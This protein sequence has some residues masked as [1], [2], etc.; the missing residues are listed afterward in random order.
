MSAPLPA[1]EP[2]RLTALRALDVLDTP[3]EQ[4]YDDLSALAAYVCQTPVALISLV[5]ENRQ[6]FKSR[7]GWTTSESPREVAFCAHTILQSDLLVVP[8]ARADER[9][10]N[11][12]LVTSPPSIRFY[13]G[14]PLVTDEGYVLGTL[15][16][17]DHQ[18]RELTTEQGR[19]LRIVSHQVMAQLQLGKQLE[20]RTRSNAQLAELNQ[21]LRCEVGQRVQVEKELRKSRERFELAVRG[22]QNGLWDW[23]LETNEVYYSPRWKSILGY[24]D[25]E[26][27]NRLEEWS[28]RLHPEERET[29][30]AANYAHIA[31]STPH[32][33]YE[34][35]LRH[36]DGSYRW[37]LSRGVAKRD[38]QG[39]AFRMAGSHTDLTDR[40]YIE[41]ALHQAN[42]R[43]ALAIRGSNIGIWE[44][45]LAGGNYSS[46]R[47][48]CIN[49]MEPL[50]Y[51]A[52]ESDVE[53]V[54]LAAQVH[55][56]DRPRVEQA[57]NVYLAGESPEYSVEFRAQ[58]RD[59]SYVWVLSRGVLVRDAAGRPVRF[60]GTRIDITERKR[61]EDALR[62]SVERFRGTFENAG[63]GIAHADFEGRWLRV[64]EKL[65]AI[66]GY[67]RDELL[68]KTF[69]DITHL[70]D[71]PISL[72]QF[73]RLLRR[74]ISGYTLEKRYVRKN[75]ST[76][77]VDLAVSLQRD[78]ADKPVY[79]I[80]V[81]QDISERKRLETEL[82]QAKEAAE[83]A[84]RAKSD[85]LA[86]VSHEVRTPLNAIM[87]MN[88]LALDTP[89]TEQQRKYL[90]V[91][92]SASEDLLEMIN[93][94]LDFSK[95]EAGKLD[96]DRSPFSLR[97]V[98]NDTMRSVALRAHR[99]GL[100]LA[101]H[102]RPQVADFFIGD[103]GRLRQV[104]TNLVANAVKF[105]DQ[106][107]VVIE[108]E[109]LEEESR[110]NPG[111]HDCLDAVPCTLLFS[112]RDTGIGIPRDKQQ[113]IFEAFE[114]VDKSTT[115]RYGGTGLG[116]SI[117]S[118]LVGLMG[119]RIT[120][121]SE[122]GR[123]STFYFTVRLN[124]PRLQ[125]HRATE[126]APNELQALRV[127]VVD[128]S[129]A[130]RSILEEW[131]RAW[132]VEATVVSDGTAALAALRQAAA[133]DR[134]YA[135]VVLDSRLGGSDALAVAEQIRQTPDLA[136]TGILLLTV[137]D[138]ATETRKWHEL[139][140]QACLMKPVA[141]EELLDTICRMRS[142]PG[143]AV[144]AAAPASRC[145]YPSAL[146]TSGALQSE[147]RL[148]ILVA[149]DN[150][151]NQA[152][153]QELLP[154]RGHTL[155]VVLDGRA[156]L[157][158][159][160]E[161]CFNVMLLDIHMPELDGFQVVAAQRQRENGTKHRL[162]IIALTA[163]STEGERE[164]CLQ[165]GMDDYLAKPVRAAQ[166]FAALDRVV[167]GAT[168]DGEKMRDGDESI[169]TSTFL[170]RPSSF[171][172]SPS[173][174]DAETLLA[175]CDGDDALLRKMCKHFQIF[176]P[177]RLAE[178]SEALLDQNGPMVQEAAHKL[179]GMVSSFSAVAAQAAA[180]L[181]HLGKERKFEE[182]MRAYPR[183]TELVGEV[184]SEIDILSIDQLQRLA[185]SFIPPH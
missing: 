103:S 108:A 56:D 178:L 110:P 176:V 119:G 181:G 139:G 149:E 9:F 53:Y 37:I 71:L 152:V 135:L 15:C 137:E 77:W 177:G 120:V 11:N 76:I 83:A 105:T 41:A 115:R 106:G 145:E 172:A 59:G 82:R 167:R 25:H 39:K 95:I 112:V 94:L 104:L 70:D 13:A 134:P 160:E 93:D 28:D 114:Q 92:Q 22:S 65:C 63:V 124:R 62:E 20:E 98:L 61:A 141:E 54:Q 2:D 31:G 173:K 121:E 100:E 99:K 80:A 40:K 57:L 16:V 86:H 30:L 35:R 113:K 74:E 147:R 84:N 148:H 129:A 17:I 155:R 184:T 34:F 8:D 164:R 79:I 151:Y 133:S 171:V 85:F 29:V 45:D 153:M 3:P 67:S 5:D 183:L 116:L 26:I 91:V 158:A 87:G 130:C 169:A 128:D 170:R 179:G 101:G 90:T 159:I 69:R 174:L 122:P 50:G 163:R 68:R 48:R 46:G 131:L 144:P 175:A 81:V 73:G 1:N 161:D 6:W 14:A 38:S 168:K 166:L 58:H 180:L 52:P 75:G 18:P 72:D 60:A 109:A 78:A 132:R 21:V 165:A 44:N 150:P 143:K 117:A 64:N 127:L 156:A 118:Q 140:I 89:V 136:S 97:A 146:I 123:G 7:V 36:K 4:A 125:P 102:I 138:Q 49:I 154:R 32:Y 66:V 27:S 42:D 43:L 157:A 111:E 182:A 47:V 19:A 126:R 33:E 12:P 10:A 107:E 24:E 96:L 51:S 185:R 23:D 55:P 142:L 88:E 162:A